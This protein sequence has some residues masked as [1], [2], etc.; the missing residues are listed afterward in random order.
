MLP[1]HFK[2]GKCMLDWT[3]RSSDGS[4]GSD[5]SDDDD[6]DDD[7]DRPSGNGFDYNHPSYKPPRSDPRGGFDSKFS[8][9]DY[10]PHGGGA[11]GGYFQFQ[12]SQLEGRGIGSPSSYAVQTTITT[13]DSRHIKQR[14]RATSEPLSRSTTT[15]EV[16]SR[17]SSTCAKFGSIEGVDQNA[18][19]PEVVSSS[20]PSRPVIITVPSEEH[21][22]TQELGLSTLLTS[23]T[24]RQAPGKS[25]AKADTSQPV[26]TPA[27]IT[28]G[29]LTQTQ[30]LQPL[31][32]TSQSFLSVRLLGSGGFSTVDEVEHSVTKLRM[33]R[34]TL[35]DR[36]PA[37]IKELWKEV[38]VLQKL[39]HPHVIRLLGA[40]SRDDKM[41]ILVSPIAD[42]TL[43]LWL[44]RFTQQQPSN[45]PQIITKIFGCLA[46][47]VRY[48]HEQRP[49]V[50]HMDIKPQNILVVEGDGEFPHVVL[51][52]FGISSSEDL[53]DGRSQPLTRRYAAPEMF[54]SVA[55]TQA[56]DIWS[57]GCVFAE[58][59][60]VTYGSS[61]SEWLRLLKE[62]SGRTGKYYWQ[63]VHSLQRRLTTVL[64]A[65]T[66]PT[67]STVANTLKSMLR[68]QPDERLCATELTMIFTPAQCCLDWPNDKATYPSPQEEASSV[69][70]LLLEEGVASC[71]Q[72]MHN[73]PA[74]GLSHSGSNAK[75]W[76]Q[77][78]SHSHE[79][80]SH[81]TSPGTEGLPT[82]L[83]D[84]SPDGKDASYVRVIDSASVEASNVQVDYAALSHVW[85]D[86]NVS[87]SSDNLQALQAHLPRELL[88]LA[89]QAAIS[90]AQNLG[91]RYIWT[92]SLCVLQDNE[93]DKQRECANMATVFR[94]AALTLVLDQLDEALNV[95]A[96]NT[97]EDPNTNEN[98]T[99]ASPQAPSVK[100]TSQFRLNA[101][102]ALPTTDF[103]TLGFA[104]DTRAWALQER[105][106]G[107][108][109]LHLGPEQ[110]YWDC[111]SLKAS[112]TFPQGLPSLV[113]EKVHSKPETQS[114]S[115]EA[116]QLRR[117]GDRASGT[118]STA[119]AAL[120]D[121]PSSIEPRR[122]R[123]CQWVKK[124]GDGLGDSMEAAQTTLELSEQR[125]CEN[126]FGSTCLASTGSSQFSDT[127][128]VSEQ[129]RGEIADDGMGESMDDEVTVKGG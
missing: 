118:D 66:E 95:P 2:Q 68:R 4:H 90:A 43:A 7:D 123:N 124:E 21:Q 33:S 99:L 82:R 103:T 116:I 111:N 6:D 18:M 80:C 94:N 52:D 19:A 64:D 46:S 53:A 9:S 107:S 48:L 120:L 22:E 63:N 60:S 8:G 25:T 71:A 72:H 112:D 36:D 47:S 58:M 122:L 92:D 23:G 54:E 125:D 62:F 15:A 110:M 34:K 113:W 31:P 102:A 30:G 70:M 38:N 128:T 108:R 73:E 40:Y 86:T 1:D 98:Q 32:I 121:H 77:Q 129:A 11:A 74:A 55:S 109:F 81:S 100:P 50:K 84:L 105:L 104:W 3:D 119:A 49:V 27:N 10:Y 106:L 42:T 117:T 91:I 37:A 57:L 67:E 101:S 78:C 45:L 97:V 87:L 96:S 65:A 16:W 35:K 51:C 5:K 127:Q 24:S 114:Q 88:S 61:N 14:P 20:V 29:Y 56:A 89:L 26:A 126:G 115:L 41:S 85:N 59:A 12:V 44:D 79:V 69:E 13:S 76:L 93:D 39:R 28:S 17:Q 83:V 75:G